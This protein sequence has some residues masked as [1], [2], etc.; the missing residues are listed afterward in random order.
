MPP[1]PKALKPYLPHTLSLYPDPREL[2]GTPLRDPPG[3]LGSSGRGLNNCNC[4]FF[5]FGVGG[6]LMVIG[7]NTFL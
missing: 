4:I 2:I 6:F 3:G 7:F 5:I 1:N